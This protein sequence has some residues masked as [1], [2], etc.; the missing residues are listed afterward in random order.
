MPLYLSTPTKKHPTYRIRGKHLG[1]KVDRSAGT[2]EKTVAQKI[3]VKIREEIERGAFARPGEQTFTDLAVSYMQAGKEARF[4]EPLIAHFRDKLPRLITQADL[5]EAATR[6]YPGATAATR[7]RQVYTPVSAILQHAKIKTGFNRPEGADGNRRNVWLTEQQAGDLIAAAR[8][9]VTAAEK[10]IE[11]TPRQFRGA[12]RARVRS[13]KRFAALCYFLLYTG[14]RLSEALNLEPGDIELPFA[15]AHVRE[16]KNDDPRPVHL[17][18]HVVAELAN[19]EFGKERVFGF[20][21]K[22]GRLY[23]WLDEIATA[24]GVT[25]PDRVAFHI[26]RHTW[27]KWMRRYAGLDTT[28][29]VA[30]R[31]W[32]SRQGAEIYEHAETTEEARKADLLPLVAERRETGAIRAQPDQTATF[33]NDFNRRRA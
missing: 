32:R 30:T 10:A 5:D 33:P 23:E 17:P 13:A 8:A 6:L 28:G 29:L 1:I 24:A 2:R 31:A 19:I 21:G 22:C 27:G 18:P 15:M 14:C 25:I 9:R 16:T 20:A 11:P 26:F 12:A 4:L 3:L 7:N